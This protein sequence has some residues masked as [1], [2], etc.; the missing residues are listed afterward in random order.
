MTTN[1]Q[2]KTRLESYKAWIL[3]QYILQQEYIHTVPF[4]LNGQGPV[5][6]S[7]IKLILG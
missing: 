4:W 7:P 5:V 2:S 6:Q 3:P 1:R